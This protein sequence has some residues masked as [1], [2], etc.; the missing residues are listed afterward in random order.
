MS[1]YTKSSLQLIWDQTLD[2]L[3]T[4]AFFDM[5]I[6]NTYIHE[7]KLYDLNQNG[8]IVII[9]SFVSR[10]IFEN[11]KAVIENA[12]SDVIDELDF[13]AALKF[14]LCLFAGRL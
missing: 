5:A 11:N 4:G 10:Q 3:K 9:P 8:A 13:D 2:K 12:L 6:F 7:S 14:F 1:N